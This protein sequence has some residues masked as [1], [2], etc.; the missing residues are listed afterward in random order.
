MIRRPPRSTLFPYTTLFRSPLTFIE[1]PRPLYTKLR[2]VEA[3]NILSTRRILPTQRKRVKPK[4]VKEETRRPRGRGDTG[5]EN[6]FNQES[7]VLSPRRRVPS[8][9]ASI[10]P[11]VSSFIVAICQRSTRLRQRTPSKER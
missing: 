8:V 6:T 3:Q 9:S 1:N 5:K 4:R 11:R 2:R 7:L 10:L